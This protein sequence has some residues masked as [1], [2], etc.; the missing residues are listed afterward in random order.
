MTKGDA[1]ICDCCQR[2]VDYVRGSRWHGKARICLPCFYV[3]YDC[4]MIEP[5]K[6]RAY[7]LAAE[8]EGRWPFDRRQS[9]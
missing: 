5:E 1:M 7:V 8:A 4:N 2:E 9:P 6:I 3:W